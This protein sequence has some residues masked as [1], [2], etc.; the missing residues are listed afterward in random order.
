MSAGDLQTGHGN[1]RQRRGG[2]SSLHEGALCRLRLSYTAQSSFDWS[3]TS[4]DQLHV[5]ANIQ[6]PTLVPQ[7]V[8]TGTVAANLVWRHTLSPTWTLALTAQGVVQDNRVHTITRTLRAL[9]INDR[10]NGGRAVLVGV[11]YKMR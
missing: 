8:R 3:A 7:G 5:D 11:T 2:K 10:L 6:G 9:N 1:L 4:K